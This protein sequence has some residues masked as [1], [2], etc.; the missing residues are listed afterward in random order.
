VTALRVAPT[1]GGLTAAAAADAAAA[2]A[3]AIGALEAALL[4]H[5]QLVSESQ[6]SKDLAVNMPD[7]RRP[8]GL[9]RR[10]GR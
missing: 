5:L 6:V 9:G 7:R 4:A 2:L 1:G 3:A 10:C 8:T